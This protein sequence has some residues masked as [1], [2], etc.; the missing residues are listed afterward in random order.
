MLPQLIGLAVTVL[1]IA[2]GAYLL[3]LYMEAVFNGRRTFLSPVLR[4][5]ERVCY[6][7]MGVKEDAEQGWKGYLVAMFLVT[8]VSMLFTY[9]IL[10][11][12]DKLLSRSGPQYGTR[13]WNVLASSRGRR[14][15]SSVSDLL[16]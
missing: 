5:V 9:V 12:Q 16:C 15:F 13:V 14:C 2:V 4:P 1:A 10:R 8:V 11:I 3:G 6:R 7:L